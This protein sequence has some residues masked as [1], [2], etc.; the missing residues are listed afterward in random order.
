MIDALL[1]VL[2]SAMIGGLVFVVAIVWSPPL[3]GRDGGA[4]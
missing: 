3:R 1:I 2:C 4:R